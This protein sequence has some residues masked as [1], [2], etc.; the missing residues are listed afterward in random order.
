MTEPSCFIADPV[1]ET[2]ER[3]LFVFLRYPEAALRRL[4]PEDVQP[5]LIAP[6]TG[7]MA[8]GLQHIN[9]TTFSAVTDIDKAYITFVVQPRLDLGTA[10][11]R[12]AL[13]VAGMTSDQPGFTPMLGEINKTPLLPT[14]GLRVTWGE[15]AVRAEDEDGPI[16]A[17]AL[18]TPAPVYRRVGIWGQTHTLLEGRR[19]IQ[20]NFWE[21][22]AYEHS[23]S[24]EIGEIH[25]HPMWG[26]LYQPGLG[27]C[28]WHQMEMRP[29]SGGIMTLHRPVEMRDAR[30]AP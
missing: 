27:A 3:E 28:G 4:L 22:E 26:A 5:M 12:F 9:A 15:R 16:L 23:G 6:G 2:I 25:A 24:A 1:T 8:I 30:T 10:T 11:P 14:R 21:G 18:T 7:L 19:Y 17:L 20:M 29:G 13:W